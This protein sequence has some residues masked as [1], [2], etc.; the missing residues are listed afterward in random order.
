MGVMLN[1]DFECVLSIPK[2]KLY[3][4]INKSSYLKGGFVV[5]NGNTIFA[6]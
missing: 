2:F 3:K 4:I 1:T 5:F 6:T